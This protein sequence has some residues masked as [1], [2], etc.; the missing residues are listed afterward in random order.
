M[1][2]EDIIYLAGLLDG[3][4]CIYISKYKRK[5]KQN[6]YYLM[7][8]VIS[9]TSRELMLWVYSIFGGCF[10]KDCHLPR[11]NRAVN[12]KIQWGDN[13]ACELLK[14]V[15]PYLKLKRP[16]A[17]LAISFQENLKELSFEDRNKF[18]CKVAELKQS[19]KEYSYPQRLNEKT[20][21]I[22]SDAIVQTV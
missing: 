12:F 7:R 14:L 11:K 20:L 3:E 22:S 9:G 1:S 8:V 5:G 18:Y 15:L 16:E 6:Y 17:E 19:Y 2:V 21:N 4:G 10:C 13:K